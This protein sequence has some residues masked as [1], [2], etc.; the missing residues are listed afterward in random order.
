VVTGFN[1]FQYAGNPAEARRLTRPGGTVAIMTWGNPDGMEAAL[2]VAA[3]RPLMPP[4]PP[5]APGHIR[6]GCRG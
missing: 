6:G 3:I 1:A 5:G 4:P 2:L